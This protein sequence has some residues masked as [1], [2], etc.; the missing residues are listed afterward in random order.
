MRGS[1][2]TIAGEMAAIGS[3]RYWRRSSSAI[4]SRVKYENFPV[5]ETIS[6]RKRETSSPSVNL[7]FPMSVHILVSRLYQGDKPLAWV[8]CINTGDK[9]DTIHAR[10]MRQMLDATART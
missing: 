8:G 5:S 1:P 3:F 2:A 6:P 9:D 10:G 4:G 7:N